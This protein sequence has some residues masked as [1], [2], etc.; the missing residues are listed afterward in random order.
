ME[1]EAQVFEPTVVNLMESNSNY[2]NWDEG[3]NVQLYVN[4]K[5]KY[6]EVY[7][8]VV[9]RSFLILLCI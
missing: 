4:T 3:N 2:S 7:D 9:L 1:E 8:A 5:N 6:L